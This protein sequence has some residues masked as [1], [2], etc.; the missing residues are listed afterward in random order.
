MFSISLGSRMSISVLPKEEVL[1]GIKL[2]K[3]YV[4]KTEDQEEPDQHYI[5]VIG[6]GIF[7][8]GILI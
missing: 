3:A 8:I 7:Q 4:F 6:A 2:N 1:I 5:L